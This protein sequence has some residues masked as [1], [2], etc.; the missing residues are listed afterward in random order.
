MHIK[1]GK[2]LKLVRGMVIFQWLE[3]LP[4]IVPTGEDL[5]DKFRTRGNALFKVQINNHRVLD[6]YNKAIATAPNGSRAMALGYANR[7]AVLIRLGR[8]REAYDD[9]QLALEGD[10]PDEKRSKVYFRQADCAVSMDMPSKLGPIIE[11]IARQSSTQL[12]SKG[13]Q[14][15]LQI[16]KAKYATA[17]KCTVEKAQ[18]EPHP[19]EGRYET[20]LEVV[21]TP[22]LGRHVIAKEPI[23]ENG[24]IATETA[25]SFIP[26]YD[27]ES[28]S[29]FASNDCQTCGRVNVIPYVCSTCGRA[30]YCSPQCKETHRSVHRF[31]CYGYKLALWQTIGIA[32]LGIRCLLDGFGTIRNEL[33]KAKRATVCYKRLIEAA[34][35]EE[36]A[37]GPYGR[38]LRLVTNFEKMDQEDVLRYAM[39]SLMLAIYLTVRTDFVSELGLPHGFMP[40]SELVVFLA[41]IIMRHIGQLVCNGHAISELRAKPCSQKFDYMHVDSFLPTAGSL[42]LYLRSTRVFTAIFPQIS[43]FNHDCDPNIRNHFEGSMLK[44][45]A[46]RAIAAGSEI[47]NCYGPNYKLMPGETRLM[48][49]QQQ[50]CFNCTCNRCRT[51]DDTF[52]KQFNKVRCPRCRECFYLELNIQDITA[53]EP[54]VCTL[55]TEEFGTELYQLLSQ[56]DMFEQV[57]H[58]DNLCIVI[59]VLYDRCAKLL[60]DFNQ[61][62]ADILQD[63]L[64]RFTKRALFNTTLGTILRK[65]AL[66]HVAIRRRQYGSMSLEFLTGCFY[67]LDIWATLYLEHGPQPV[68]L[69]AEELTA[70]KEFRAAL[71]MVGEDTRTLILDYMKQSVILDEGSSGETETLN[72]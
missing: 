56:L 53:G 6:M 51:G 39:V 7:A 43:M 59:P 3:S 62:K 29:L 14:Q 10:Y 69:K 46:T 22:E 32:H 71:S 27:P 8:F 26:V 9:C 67:L 24:L 18:P 15:K 38:V 65:L 20:A 28:R 40:E 36:N 70:L 63:I 52:Y 58:E 60:K 44:V 64:H 55:C 66:K 68:Q 41:A 2:W 57:Q 12:L 16:L 19:V 17:E 13:E 34:S 21:V 61:T 47:V 25:V 37:F 5:S 31:E 4:G 54:L 1:N 49:L 11:G 48:L 72:G 33:F 45:Y 42:H 30:C 23:E 50:Y 35:G